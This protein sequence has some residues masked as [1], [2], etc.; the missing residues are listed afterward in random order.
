M[1]D[2]KKKTIGERIREQ[3]SKSKMSTETL[4]A[5]A[6]ISA[7]ALNRIENGLRQPR[8]ATLAQ[9]S[10]ALGM[11]MDELNGDNEPRNVDLEDQMLAEFRASENQDEL[12]ALIRAYKRVKAGQ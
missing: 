7:G 6:G 2:Q 9:I 8:S 11:T 3:R 4:A 10:R 5:L 1:S 12:L